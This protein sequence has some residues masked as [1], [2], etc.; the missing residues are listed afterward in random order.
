M[1]K[2]QDKMFFGPDHSIC[3]PKKELFVNDFPDASFSDIRLG[4]DIKLPKRPLKTIGGKTINLTTTITDEKGTPLPG[5][6]ANLVQESSIGSAAGPRGLLILDEIPRDSQIRISHLG[7]ETVILPVESIGSQVVL[8]KK[9]EELNEFVGTA[10]KV[11]KK[12]SMGWVFGLVG[13]GLLL[14]WALGGKNPVA[15][16]TL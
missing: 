1:S 13:S 5:A 12:A 9:V 4:P 10:P 6:N 2:K 16:E 7:K 14:T 3:R 8:R 11:T 15:K